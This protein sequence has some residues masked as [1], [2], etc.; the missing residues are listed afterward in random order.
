[1]VLSNRFLA[2]TFSVLLFIQA[3]IADVLPSGRYTIRSFLTNGKLALKLGNDPNGPTE[4]ILMSDS[5]ELWDIKALGDDEYV[6]SAAS[7]PELNLATSEEDRLHAIPSSS[8]QWKLIQDERT[9]KGHF[10]IVDALRGFEK[11][12]KAIDPDDGDQVFVGLLPVGRSLPPFY[13]PP[14][15]WVIEV[16]K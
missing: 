13:P 15:V 14:G 8:A 16:A 11:A 6:I 2:I 12:W 5:T 4:I 3:V 1:M 9:G 10:V 7:N